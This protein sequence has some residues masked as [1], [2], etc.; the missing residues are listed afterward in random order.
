MK[1][2]AKYYDL[3]GNSWVPGR[4]G[5]MEDILSHDLKKT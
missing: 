1:L 4:G 5:E 2:G 3:L